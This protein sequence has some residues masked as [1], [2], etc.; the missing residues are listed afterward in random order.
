MSTI[1]DFGIPGISSGILQP[2]LKNRWRVLFSNWGRGVDSQPVSAQVINLTRP[3][4]S[5]DE[6]ELHRYNSRAWVGAKHNYE[7][8]TLTLEDD[9]TGTATRALRDQAQS[10]QWLIGS[11]GPWLA[12]AGE[13]SLYKF[14]TTLDMLDGNETVIEQWVLEGCWLQTINYGDVDYEA[15]EK[16]TIELTM[17]FD[18]PRQLIGGY[19]Q[20][21][22]VATGGP[23]SNSNAAS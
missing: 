10:Q 19:D 22:G 5:F 4:I 11:E 20:G 3:T 15:S 14:V 13:G 12:A 16:L 1:N 21:Q 2:K 6:I 9:V 18:H 8:I 17:R 23:G 7:P